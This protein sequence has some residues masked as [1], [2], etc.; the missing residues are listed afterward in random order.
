MVGSKTYKNP[1]MIDGVVK[2]DYNERSYIDS[3]QPIM[4]CSPY[5]YTRTAEEVEQITEKNI[6]DTRLITATMTVRYI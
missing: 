1:E 3:M 2:I 5:A 6:S 4:I